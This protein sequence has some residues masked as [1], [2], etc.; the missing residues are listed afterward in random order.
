MGM[1]RD[2]VLKRGGNSSKLRRVESCT[3]HQM[4]PRT[5]LCLNVQD[6]V[7][8]LGVKLFNGS[9][10]HTWNFKLSVTRKFFLGSKSRN[11]RVTWIDS[12]KFSSLR[13]QYRGLPKTIKAAPTQNPFK[14]TLRLYIGNNFSRSN[15]VTQILVG[16]YLSC[17][18]FVKTNILKS[19]NKYVYSNKNFDTRRNG[20]FCHLSRNS[21]RL[22]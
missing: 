3:R 22:Y 14:G 6:E 16:H 15:R 18:S 20:V 7:L 17:Y 11:R 12:S 21:V 13:A 1:Y 19:K 8:L 10:E 2:L 9:N 4:V 5:L